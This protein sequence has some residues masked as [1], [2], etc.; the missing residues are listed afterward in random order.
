MQ[1]ERSDEILSL[2]AVA[3]ALLVT[4]FSTSSCETVE[5]GTVTYHAKTDFPDNMDL[6]MS[7]LDKGF[8]EAGLSALPVG[9]H[10]WTLTGEKKACNE[11][12]KAA[13][14][15]RCQVIDK[16]RTDVGYQALKGYTVTLIASFTEDSEIASYT[17]KEENPL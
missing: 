14:L 11:K 12:A 9:V 6:L 7:A 8:E 4:A 5:S 3:G 13:F 2:I 10:Y 17:F 16:D 15:A 1:H